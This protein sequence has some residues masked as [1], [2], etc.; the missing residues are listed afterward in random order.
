MRSVRLWITVAA[1]LVLGGAAL[2]AALPAV[3]R[4]AAARQ[5][6][7]MTGRSVAIADV[8]LNLFTGRFAV[9][10]LRVDGAEGEPPLLRLDR[11]EA[12][13]RAWRLLRGR[14][15]IDRLA[16][17][18]PA[19]HVVRRADGTLSAGEVIER[20]RRGEPRATPLPLAV[21]R[22]TVRGGR[23]VLEDRAV[24]PS[25][26]WRLG[27]LAVDGQRLTAITE[28]APGTLS[29]TFTLQGAQGVIAA[30][31][32]GLR[33]VRARARVS[34]GAVDLA[35]LAAYMA[36]SPVV[37]AGGRFSGAHA[38]RIAD[39]AIVSERGQARIA[40][41][42]LRRPGQDEPLVTADRV[43]LDARDVRYARGELVAGRLELRTSATVTE[44]VLGPPRRYD[45]TDL[46]AVLEDARLPGGQPARAALTAGLPRGGVLDV[47]GRVNLAPA[48]ADLAVRVNGL[49]LALGLP[50][51][52]AGTPV[53]VGG[54]RLS[55]ALQVTYAHPDQLR[56]GGDFALEDFTILRTGQ[57]DPLIRHPR[58][59]GTVTDLTILGRQLAV[60]RIALAGAPTIVDGRISPPQRFEVAA[61][62]LRVEDA[63]WPARAPA[64]VEGH[65]RLGGGG[66]A[67]LTGRVH[68][69]T[70][71][72]EV[73]TTV[74]DLDLARFARYLPAGAPLAVAGG[75]LRGQVQLRHER[76]TGVVLTGTGTI[77]D[78]A[79]VRPGKPE[80]LVRDPALRL[81]FD[82]VRIRNGAVSG[83]R[84]AL[85]GA[86]TVTAR[87]GPEPRG[88]AIPALEA[89][90]EAVA[91]PAR[92]PARI[93]IGARLPEAGRLEVAGTAHLGT[94]AVALTVALRDA[95]LAPLGAFLPLSGEIRGRL[96]A[97]LAARGSL[98]DRP[99]L[100]VS[101]QVTG[102]A[103]RLGPRRE[104]PVR[105][106]R[107]EVQGLALRWPE[108]LEVERLAIVQPS[109]LVERTEDGQFPLRAMLAPRP[110]ARP[111]EAAA[112]EAGRD[113]R[114]PG[115][116]AVH[117]GEVS[118]TGGDVR[119]VDRTTTP[120]Y[121]E[122]L[123]DLVVAVREL[124][125]G[126]ERPADVELTALLGA[127][128]A[129]SL[130]GVMDP[131]GHPFFLEVEGELR[132][133]S[134]ARTN[135]YL[136]RFLDWIAR[137]GELTSTLHYRIV[138]T[139]VEGRNEIVVQGLDVEPA[140]G[141]EVGRALGLPLALIVSLLKNP[142]G[143]IRLSI[144]ITGEL[145]SPRFSVADAIRTALRNL[146][147]RIVTGPFAAIGR[148][149]RRDDD[150][151]AALRME[152]VQFRPGV[153]W[154]DPAGAEHLQRVADLLRAS[155]Y[156]ALTLQP[157]VTE[158]DLQALRARRVAQQVQEIQR[159]EGGDFA[160]AARRLF[161]RR[162]PGRPLP[163]SPDE[164]IAALQ[165][166]EALAPDAGQRLAVRRAESTRQHLIEAAGIE[167]GRLRVAEPGP[168]A[169][170]PRVEFDLTPGP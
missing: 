150:Q 60:R 53:S 152:P 58:L 79:F 38:L 70:L 158:A 165:A 24:A 52:P 143:D 136:R 85:A 48:A 138:G 6:T 10:D 131:F 139:E 44:A 55:A 83:R 119:Y 135:P 15:P 164:A 68:P 2:L 81:S 56:A 22:L 32:I 148:L 67:S 118:V 155:P 146:A 92:A 106:E 61:L 34:L 133:F 129:L 45:V 98:G 74:A 12:R 89:R 47:R 87:S 64:R 96:D 167:P 168:A 14:L 91:W 101:G 149:F 25:R 132:R 141:E 17:T 90:V 137:S 111:A 78:A 76:A 99:A 4:L 170:V 161:A 153:A 166:Q 23:A 11:L 128:G 82:D 86:P 127:D 40:D 140:R 110:A 156:V 35:P 121:S 77:L 154:V 49:D 105:I 102:R 73:R 39:G 16:L 9:V 163:D 26:T 120:F 31:Q 107:V 145:G 162:L 29:A 109:V 21:D 1:L 41:L 94:G 50:Y 36:G 104:A 28:D 75:R 51:L 33:P 19:L 42:V 126:R 114:A 122:E 65:A 144:P 134:V 160:A 46:H 124:S 8:D 151:P 62:R 69:Q 72:T 123:R 112:P 142:A 157:V 37:L 59:R 93:W 116:L 30:E 13:F 3:V 66:T 113:D 130:R 54:G 7:A 18:G 159:A 147:A 95:A 117:V 43:A 103:L 63:T 84:L 27:D 169:G 100:G 57:R 108:R 71:A 125:T 80:L 97:E 88:V 20:L 115:R 5:L